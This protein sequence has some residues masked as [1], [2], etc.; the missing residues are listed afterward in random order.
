MADGFTGNTVLNHGRSSL[1]LGSWLKA[2]LLEETGRGNWG[3]A[4]D[5]LK[6]LKQKPWISQML[7]RSCFGLQAPVVAQKTL[8]VVQRCPKK[9][10]R[11]L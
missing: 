3:T 1:N 11:E 4:Q 5:R 2:L 8:Y 10:S 6:S 7:E 9:L